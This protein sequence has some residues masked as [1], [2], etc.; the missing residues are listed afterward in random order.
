M[1]A[2]A[3]K[4]TTAEEKALGMKMDWEDDG[5]YSVGGLVADI[6]ARE[7]SRAERW[8]VFG[9]GMS[10]RTNNLAEAETWLRNNPAARLYELRQDADR[11]VAEVLE[12]YSKRPTRQE[13]D[14]ARADVT[15][16]VEALA[17]E[18]CKFCGYAYGVQDSLRD[19]ICDKCQHE[20][21]LAA[22]AKHSEAPKA[23]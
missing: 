9:P 12:A 23:S 21:E 3:V 7:A 1:S 2:N 13:H 19:V 16:L 20:R 8:A 11:R 17:K 6:E 18:A 4:S 5:M 10:G 22:L 15:E 14:K